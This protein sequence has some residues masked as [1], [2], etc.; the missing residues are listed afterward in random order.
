MSKRTK[1][2]LS[3]FIEKAYKWACGFGEFGEEEL[4]EVKEFLWSDEFFEEVKR[5]MKTS[6]NQKE[7][8][9]EITLIISDMFSELQTKVE[10]DKSLKN[11][12]KDKNIKLLK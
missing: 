1:K 8:N 6:S 10:H 4:K 9:E 3:R 2:D 7:F 12:L 11:I 5:L